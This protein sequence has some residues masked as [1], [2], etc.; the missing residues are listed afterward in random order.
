MRVVWCGVERLEVSRRKAFGGPLA[1]PW[2]PAAVAAGWGPPAESGAAGAAAVGLRARGGVCG[3]LPG[4]GLRSRSGK[5]WPGEKQFRVYGSNCWELMRLR[6]IKRAP[7][8]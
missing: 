1:G 5:S 8:A 7:D 2:G 4:L 3:G 6:L